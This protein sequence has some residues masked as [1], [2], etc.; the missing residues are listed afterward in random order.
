MAK[1]HQ[2]GRYQEILSIKKISFLGGQ[3]MSLKIFS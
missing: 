3:N 2:V 1:A